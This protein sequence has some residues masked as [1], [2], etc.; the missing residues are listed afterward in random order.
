MILKRRRKQAALRHE[1]LEMWPE[2]G[3]F[4]QFQ[5]M[6][7]REDRQMFAA[8]GPLGPVIGNVFRTLNPSQSVINHAAGYQ[9][10]FDKLGPMRVPAIVHS[11]PDHGL[12]VVAR[13]DGTDV[14]KL[15]ARPQKDGPEPDEAIRLA[16]GWLRKLHDSV[17]KSPARIGMENLLRRHAA[18]TNEGPLKAEIYRLGADLADLFFH[19]TK[20]HKDYSAR[21]VIVGPHGVM[22]IDLRP[23][24]IRPPQFDVARFLRTASGHR[25]SRP[26]EGELTRIGVPLDVCKAFDDGYRRNIAQDSL[27]ELQL[28][29]EMAQFAHEIE[30]MSR[31]ELA[32]RSRRNPMFKGQLVLLRQ[33]EAALS[34]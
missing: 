19:Q 33:I 7:D 34:R 5:L 6:R 9:N 2:A 25:L 31:L 21:N 1:V 23:T 15:I 12:L 14:G 13:P 11:A 18:W 27:S 24:L 32:R 17:Q 26:Y 29:I 28:L 4:D 8:D 3:P 10:V 22:A 20:F 16:A 30:P